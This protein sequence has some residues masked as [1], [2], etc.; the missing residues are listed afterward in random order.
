MSLLATTSEIGAFEV[1]QAQ[2]VFA[3]W[4]T[5]TSP[6][7]Q[8]CI[9]DVHLTNASLVLPPLKLNKSLEPLRQPLLAL[10]GAEG[11]GLDAHKVKKLRQQMSR[12]M[13]A[14]IRKVEKAGLS[15]EEL[16][17]LDEA[18]KFN[19]LLTRYTGFFRMLF[20][21]QS[22]ESV[23]REFAAANRFV[24][25]CFGS[26]TF[27]HVQKILQTPASKPLGRFLYAGMWKTL[28]GNG[29]KYWHKD[30]LNRLRQAYENGKT[31]VYVAGGSDVY[32][33][34]AH[35]IYNI[36]VIDPQLNGAQDNYYA[37][38]WEWL[39]KGTGPSGGAGDE[40][41][42]N[43]PDK[44]IVARRAKLV[45]G[46][47]FSVKLDGGEELRPVSSTVVWE[48]FENDVPKGTLTFER[49]LATQE[50][51]Q[52]KDNEELLMSFN[53]LFFII[54][55]VEQDGW[56]IDPHKFANN[57]SIHIKQLRKPVTKPMMEN[58][59]WVE[60]HNLAFL[61]LGTAVK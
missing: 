8:R 36:K 44:K 5:P 30:T 34:L 42:F 32:Q 51:F 39:L 6:Y 15:S 22:E 1:R 18:T 38:Q 21:D 47:R 7:F 12:N 27:L 59:A 28:A 40:L 45:E 31:V 10:I 2:D 33:L 35:G 16:N 17:T 29:W 43:T 56:P 20:A 61:R 50:D 57:I 53:E 19:M 41:L 11:G 24:E 54:L 46:K 14:F 58:M 23:E 48:I 26:K 60:E 25:F 55:P 4:L 52:P 3:R 13:G 49:R 37:D 9:P